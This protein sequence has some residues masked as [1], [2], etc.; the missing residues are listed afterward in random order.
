VANSVSTVNPTTTQDWIY[1]SESSGDGGVHDVKYLS[2]DTPIGGLPPA[3]DAGEQS[4]PQ[5]C[6]KAVFTDL[7]T[8]GEL[9]AQYNSVPADCPTNTTLTAQQKALEFLFFDLSACVSDDS[10]PTPQPPMNA[11]Q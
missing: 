6:G 2:F 9:F 7:H 3:A 1:D 10:K 11:P 4:T 5:Y 8:G